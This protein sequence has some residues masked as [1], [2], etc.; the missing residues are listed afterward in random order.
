MDFTVPREW[1]PCND[2]ILVSPVE[3]VIFSE[4]ERES[5]SL[6]AVACPSVVCLS[7]V[8]NARA[9]Y[10]GD[11]NFQQYFYSIWYLGHPLTSTENLTMIVPEE[12]LRRGS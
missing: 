7:V 4:H 6:Y 5:H 8:C 10:S 11:S 1:S 9:P 12:P 3:L 2:A